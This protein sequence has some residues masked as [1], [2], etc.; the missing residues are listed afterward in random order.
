MPAPRVGTTQQRQLPEFDSAITRALEQQQQQAIKETSMLEREMAVLEAKLEPSNESARHLAEAPQPQPHHTP[1]EETTEQR[2]HGRRLIHQPDSPTTKNPA[3]LLRSND[4]DVALLHHSE[5]MHV[6][7]P[8]FT[9]EG[10]RPDLSAELPGHRRH[11]EHTE[12]EQPDRLFGVRGGKLMVAERRR[13]VE[14]PGSSPAR[15]IVGQPPVAAN[16][17]SDSSSMRTEEP[18]KQ[19][20]SI[21]CDQESP[22]RWLDHNSV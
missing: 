4:K 19:P 21:S 8:E 2:R 16:P 9:K 14:A 1:E 17:D 20:K 7:D 18:A 12:P 5:R 15:E 11:F 6:S 10:C 22:Y 3:V 13:H